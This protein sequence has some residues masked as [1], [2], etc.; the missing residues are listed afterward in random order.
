M[1]R[2]RI[3][4]SVVVLALLV[5]AGA[6]TLIRGENERASSLRAPLRS[7]P[8]FRRITPAPFVA[9]STTTTPAPVAPVPSAPVSPPSSA[10]PPAREPAP[11]PEA[12]PA[13]PPEPAPPATTVLSGAAGQ[14]VGLINGVRAGLGLAPYAVDGELTANAQRWAQSMA[15]SGAMAH[16]SDLSGGLTA[17]WVRLGENVGVGGDVVIVHN[18]MVA[19]S[20]HYANM[21]DSAFGYVGVG[22]VESGGTLY[23]AEEFMQ[24]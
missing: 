1:A 20:G 15:A 19:S 4:P 13:S 3:A 16:Q 5:G 8:S 2:A 14:L 23:V 18:A 12:A 7:A 11:E 6:C 24:L 21:A 17:S 22:V 9:P 10:A